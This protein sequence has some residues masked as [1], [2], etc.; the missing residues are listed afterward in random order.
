MVDAV[1]PGVSEGWLGQVCGVRPA[2]FCGAC[3]QCRGG[4][5]QLCQNFQC[6]GNTQDGGYAEY[7]LAGAD[8]LIPLG[9]LAPEIAVWMEPLACVIQALERVGGAQIFGPVLIVGAGVLGKLMVQGLGATSLAQVAIVDPNPDRVADAITNGAEAGWVIPRQGHVPGLVDALEKW[10]PE[11]IPL[12]VDTSGAPEAI[13]RAVEWV[14]PG[15]KVLM[16]GVTAPDDGLCVPV[17]KFF[18]KEVTLLASSGMSPAA[19]ETAVHFLREGR[20][21]P[22]RFVSEIIGLEDLPAHLLGQ[23]LKTNGKVLV[24]PGHQGE[25]RL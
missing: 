3:V 4:N 25:E 11:G 19:F 22:S 2:R 17:Q 18:S 7:T 14:A 24:H 12:I 10:A 1:G 5:P 13:R 20:M 15:G 21:D 8:Q 9:G 23:T 16:F 6:L